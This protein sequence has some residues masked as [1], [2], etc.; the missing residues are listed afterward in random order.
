MLLRL[1][2]FEGTPAFFLFLYFTLS[3]AWKY[4]KVA[5]SPLNKTEDRNLKVNLVQD[6]RRLS[7]CCL[8]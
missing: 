8:G 3:I 7:T 5:G 2:H 1:E 4:R 6:R